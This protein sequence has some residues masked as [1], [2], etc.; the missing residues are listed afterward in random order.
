MQILI[1]G[2]AGFIGFNLAHEL[3]KSKNKLKVYG[4]DNMSNYYSVNLKKKRLRMLK[5]FKNFKFSNI[6]LDNTVK[7]KKYFNNKNF[8][9]I[10]HFA[11][12]AGVLY[13]IKN[14]RAYLNSNTKGFFNLL[15]NFKN[16]KIKTIFYA[17]SSSVYGNSKKFPLKENQ[18]IKPINFY[19]LTK[20]NNEETAEIFSHFYKI[21]LVGLR[22]FTV[23][24]EWGRPDMVFHKLFLSAFKKKIFQLNNKGNHLRDFTYIGDVVKVLINLMNLKK[25]KQKKHIIFNICS[26]KPVKLTSL[27]HILNLKGIKIKLKMA[28]LQLADI[29]KT[30][31]CN[32]KLLKNFKNFKFTPFEKAFD[33]TINWYQK[34]INITLK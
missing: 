17:S 31:G 33:K 28:P 22:F 12:Q 20:K 15:E 13:S 4:I 32:K 6:S 21:N 19:G 9:Y 26:N 29:I 18:I 10:F 25:I 34:N 5:K 8:D 16:K 1:T 30:H 7:L 14:P 2:A 3:L 27:I 11:A 23:F 24:G